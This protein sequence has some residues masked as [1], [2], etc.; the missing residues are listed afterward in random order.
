MGKTSTASKQKYN[1][2]AY[3]RVV[4]TVKKGDKEKIIKKASE[5]GKSVNAYIKDLINADT[6]GMLKD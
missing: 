3:E 4:L 1:K 2:K 5:L 6:N